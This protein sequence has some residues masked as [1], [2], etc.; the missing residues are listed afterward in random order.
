[1]FKAIGVTH[2]VDTDYPAGCG[3][4]ES[5][6]HVLASFWHPIAFA[7][8]V[9]ERPVSL[10]LL[11]ID[12][13]VYRTSAGL[14]VARDRCPHRGVHVS[15]GRVVDDLLVCPMH[16]LHF[17]AAG[18]CRKIPSL[19]DQS[20]PISPAM[21]LTTYRCEQ[22]YGIIWTCLKPE[23]IAPLPQW[24]YL[25]GPTTRNVYVPPDMW[26][27]SAARH[28]ENFNDVAHFPWVHLR[29]FGS[30]A[31]TQTPRY[32]VEDTEWG[33]RFSYP[34][35]EG[36]N[37]FPDG[38]EA[39]NR[40]VTYTFELTFPFSTQLTVDP[41]GSDF[42]HY[43]A[44]TVCPVSVNQSRIFQL[45]TDTTGRPDERFWIEDSMAINADDKPL[46]ESQPPEL[47][48]DPAGELHHIPADRW[49]IRYRQRLVEQFGLGRSD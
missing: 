6:W 21:R 17:D 45:L 11:D 32:E 25:D 44:D 1:M 4:G 41:H 36:G 24:P 31:V 43:F 46:V 8:E 15:A 13:V 7:H 34:Y 19:P 14:T 37:R 9:G 20:A 40:D 29:S 39:E 16:G 47:P 26:R 35:E 22:R 48:L 38:V 3:F 18:V 27:A 33:L 2:R 30:D 10:R 23:A 49:S 5:D 28:V 42:V 12:L